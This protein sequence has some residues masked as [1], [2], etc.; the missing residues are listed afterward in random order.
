MNNEQIQEL[1]AKIIKK[2]NERC[3]YDQERQAVLY[4]PSPQLTCKR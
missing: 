3:M 4:G 2:L 1:K